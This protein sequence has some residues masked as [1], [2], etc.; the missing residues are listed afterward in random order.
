MKITLSK[1]TRQRLEAA[2]Q[3]LDELQREQAKLE[4]RG[5][6]LAAELEALSNA[7]TAA[8]QAEREAV[9]QAAFSESDEGLDEAHDHTNR[10]RA[11]LEH[12]R[13]MLS[14]VQEELT[15]LRGEEYNRRRTA[16]RDAEEDAA[17]EASETLLQ[18]IKAQADAVRLAWEMVSFADMHIERE[19]WLQELFKLPRRGSRADVRRALM[20][21]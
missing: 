20:G 10:C 15:R 19:S 2:T 13:E 12:A 3:A 17:L 16:M 7:L 5:Q 18:P 14:I 6:Q 8:E 1:A 21:K 4:A 11:R 9:R